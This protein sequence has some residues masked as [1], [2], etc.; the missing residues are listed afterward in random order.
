[1]TWQAWYMLTIV[2]LVLGALAR[3]LAAPDALL[4]GAAVLAGVA[5]IVTP[6]QLFSGFANEGMLTVAALFVVAAALRETG[7]LDS[8][9]NWFLGKAK[10]E[11]SALARMSVSV[12]T[13]SAFL[14]NTPIVAM[15]LP[16]LTNWCRKNSV[17]P[18]RVLIPLSYLTI[19]GGTCTLIGTS[20]NIVVNGLMI[21]AAESDVG[22]HKT[23][24]PMSMFELAY[25]GLPIAIVGTLYL[26]FVGRR[27]LPD[28]KDPLA[29]LGDSY[30]EYLVNM[31]VQAG[32]RLIGQQV[33]AAGLRHLPGLFLVEVVREGQVFAP[34]PPD[35][36]MLEGDLLTFTGAIATIVDLE[37][38]PGLVPVAPDTTEL[39]STQ[40]RGRMLCEAVIS[41]TS[42]LIGKSIRDAD[43]R[44][45][46]NAV[47]IAVHRG[48]Q[49][50]QGRVGDIVIQNGDT[51]L[52]QTGPH[53][54]RAHR[55]NP[56]FFLVGSVEDSRPVR[57]EK[58]VLS[59]VFLGILILLLVSGKISTV[60]AAFIVAGLMVGSRC[61]SISDARQ[62][63]DWQTLIT[64]AA[65]F[66]LGKALEHSG[67]VRLV[68]E[69]VVSTAGTWGPY[70]ILFAVY[71]MTNILTELLTN[72]AAAALMFPF[73]VAIAQ[74]RGLDPRPFVMAVTFAASAAFTIPIGYQTHLMVYGP[75]G[76]KFTDFIRVGLP[77]SIL[78]LIVAV[79]LI[80]R[81][82]HF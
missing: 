65:S 33:E 16:V 8:I 4:L 37:R 41:G 5:G 73:A 82:W 20:T 15:F 30:R 17:S 71:L 2:V 38:I 12:T 31:R 48:G 26:L 13:L 32:C 23:L 50:L 79:L 10:T 77:L 9:G 42:P 59:F 63:V 52:M 61:I 3:N 44:A 43:F 14:N 74:E 51:L 18:S 22:L 6:E 80:P 19:L 39:H 34:V 36:V 78:I 7:A 29:R 46:Y 58:A 72:N 75:G 45:L 69:I 1:M 57:H 47:V 56:D 64:I 70:A 62:S 40:R 76:Y 68:A 11:R 24:H 60:M 21:E 35:Q 67:L 28:Y 81:V 66:G 55:N 49:R 27:L 25:V 54:I 53:F